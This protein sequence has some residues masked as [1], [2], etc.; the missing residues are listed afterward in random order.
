MSDGREPAKYHI[1][2][3]AKGLGAYDEAQVRR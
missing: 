2:N 3:E 1:E